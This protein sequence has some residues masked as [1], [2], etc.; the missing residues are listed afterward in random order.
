MSEFLVLL[1]KELR[2]ITKEKT[3]MLAVIVQFAIA[4]FSSVILQGVMAFYDPNSI[5]W[6]TNVIIR[7]GF[8]GQADSPMLTYLK[9]EKI[10]TRSFSELATAEAAF[11]SGQIDTILIMPENQSGLVNMKLIL[12]KMEA[13]RTV[14]LVMLDEPL[15]RYED[16]LREANGVLVDFKDYDS[17]PFSTYEFLY[18][19]LIPILML[20]PALI[21]GSIVI[22]AVSEEFENKTLDTLISTPVSAG[23]VFASKV[24]AAVITAVIQIVMWAGLLRWS[25]VII[26]RLALVLLLAISYTITISF[27]AAIIALF[28]KD[29]QRAQFTYSMVLIAVGAVS[30]FL[31]PSPLELLIKLSSEAPNISV[32]GFVLYAVLAIFA[33]L[34]FF[35]L[36]E[37]RILRGS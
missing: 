26:D 35:Y 4:S 13:K 2:S 11:R 1:R 22:D 27:G 29:R 32:L 23:Q 3:I 37:R 5:G 33:G 12:P 15:R 6:S 18:A 10:I 8:V 34:A 30:S 7:A 17:K 28:L 9:D 19:I 31:N 25:G 16:Y 14:I 36:S 21:A 20:F 24:S